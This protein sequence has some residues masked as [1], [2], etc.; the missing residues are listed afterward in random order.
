MP[1][2]EKFDTE[3]NF[4]ISN[5][6]DRLLGKSLNCK[7]SV[8]KLIKGKSELQYNKKTIWFY[9]HTDMSV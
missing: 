5:M 1:V 3:V 9:P 6:D 8:T 2:F 7:N 4:W